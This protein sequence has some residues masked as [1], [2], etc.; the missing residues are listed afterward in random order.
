MRLPR[1]AREASESASTLASPSGSTLAGESEGVALEDSKLTHS[2]SCKGTNRDGVFCSETCDKDAG[3]A[4][5]APGTLRPNCPVHGQLFSESEVALCDAEPRSGGRCLVIFNTCVYDLSN[6][7]HPGGSRLLKGHAGRDITE[8]FQEVG[9]SVHAFK[10]L[11]ALCVGVV[12]ERLDRHKQTVGERCLCGSGQAETATLS[13]LRYRGLAPGG[14]SSEAARQ[15]GEHAGSTSP[16]ATPSAHE[17]IDF[18]KPLLPQVWR[19]S[20]TDYERLIEVPCMIEG[21]MTLMPYAWMEPLSQT[22]WWVIPLLWLPVVFWCIRENLKTLSPTC[23]F[24]S[25]SVG[26][27][28]W[29]LLEYVMHRFLFHFPEQRLPD[30]RLIRIF[31]FLVH[32]VHHLLPLDPLRL[33]VPPALFVALASGVYGVFSLLL[34]QWAIQAGCPG[35]LLGYIAYDVIHY[36]THHM[37]FLQRVSHIR[38]MKRYHMR[39]HFR[40]PLLGFGVSSKIWDW[41]FGTLLP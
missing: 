35:A 14:D 24:V 40:Y 32:A 31:H 22:R 16:T 3:N 15:L 5:F 36:S 27:A 34:P 6:F 20:K 41:V 38:E 18:T 21:S 2:A 29:T 10:L 37:A 25:V 28:L 12:K 17:L 26:L 30:S 1:Y 7:S 8:P 11:D 9:H 4:A 33:V 13:Q 39:H 23:C 19:L